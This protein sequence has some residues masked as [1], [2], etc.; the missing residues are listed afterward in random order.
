M[1][2]ALRDKNILYRG[3]RLLGARDVFTQ[4]LRLN[5]LASERQKLQSGKLSSP[6]LFVP[7]SGY[8]V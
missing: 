6:A 4:N 2:Q 7:L 1:M 8:R 5:N 3:A